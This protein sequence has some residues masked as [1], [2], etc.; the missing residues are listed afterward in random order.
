MHVFYRIFFLLILLN[1]QPDVLA[2]DKDKQVNPLQLFMDKYF[3]EEIFDSELNMSLIVKA[4]PYAYIAFTLVDHGDHDIAKKALLRLRFEKKLQKMDHV[5]ARAYNFYKKNS[6]PVPSSIICRGIVCVISGCWRVVDA[7]DY[8]IL[9]CHENCCYS[10]QELL[11]MSSQPF[12]KFPTLFVDLNSQIIIQ[13]DPKSQVTTMTQITIKDYSKPQLTME[14]IFKYFPDKIS[15]LEFSCKYD[16]DVFLSACKNVRIEVIKKT[17]E[18]VVNDTEKIS[19]E[20]VVNLLAHL[21]TKLKCK[22]DRIEFQMK[23]KYR[24]DPVCVKKSL[25]AGVGAL[26]FS[27]AAL[28]AQSK[29]GMGITKKQHIFGDFWQDLKPWERATFVSAISAAAASAFCLIYLGRLATQDLNED[30]QY[31]SMYRD[32]LKFV[33]QL[34]VEYAVK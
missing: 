32:L 6:Q 33:T 20:S 18:K 31:L 15:K 24:F 3:S 12:S 34:Q 16:Q 10:K 4:K 23:H 30:N 22:I 1:S 2:V 28:Y 9:F 26:A 27:L 21:N 7:D 25:I 5:A 11:R 19:H 14:E 13:V 29:V 8:G 17:V